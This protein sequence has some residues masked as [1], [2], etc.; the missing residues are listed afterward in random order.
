NKSAKPANP[1]DQS[2]CDNAHTIDAHL[3]VRII[4]GGETLG[5]S[6]RPTILDYDGAALAP[7][8][9]AEPLGKGDSPLALSRWSRAAQPS[10]RRPPGLLR[11]RRER[12]RRRAAEKRDELAPSHSITSSAMASSLSGI[13]RPSDFAVFALMISS[14]LVGCRTGRSAGFSPLR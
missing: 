14:N 8:E 2:R 6:F 7:A 13:W 5:A 4:P 3:D 11:A 9:H 12:P 1:A 10:D